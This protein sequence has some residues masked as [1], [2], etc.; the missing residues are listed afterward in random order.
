M[1]ERVLTL[2]DGEHDVVVDELLSELANLLLLLQDLRLLRPL[3][4]RQV[5]HEQVSLIRLS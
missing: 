5:L 2:D 1:N 4:L 3:L